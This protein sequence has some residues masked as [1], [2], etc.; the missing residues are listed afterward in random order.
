MTYMHTC[1][2]TSQ[3]LA[4]RCC[5]VYVKI[6]I[7][8]LKYF[9]RPDMANKIDMNDIYA[10]DTLLSSEL[11]LQ[12]KCPI[13]EHLLDNPVQAECGDRFCSDCY[14]STFVDKLATHAKY[15]LQCIHTFYNIVSNMTTL[16]SL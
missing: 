3:R 15:C 9:Y 5:Y 12:Y 16:A 7:F 13:C 8:L 6:I 2:H 11:N 4:P 1:R 14:K 10:C